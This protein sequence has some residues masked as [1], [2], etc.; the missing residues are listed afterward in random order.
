MLIPERICTLALISTASSLFNT[1]GFLENLRNRANLFIPRPLDQQVENVKQ[2]LYTKSWLSAPDTLEPV[3]QPFPTNGDR[4]AA[5]EVWKRSQP[6]YFPKAGFLL[7]AIAAGWHYKSP[8][9]LQELA[10]NVGKR[11]ILVVHGTND[12]MLKFPL[13]VVLWRGLEKGEGRTGRE[14]IGMERED[15]V[16]VEGEVEKRFIR[17]QG[18]VIPAEMREEF[19]GWLEK[20]FERGIK[21]NEEE[22]I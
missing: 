13:G 5:N 22:G 12:Q 6:G 17:G 21:M 8:Q 1:S 4:F 14:Y 16:W 18:H 19:N 11:R 20:L 3:V 9:Q 2:N 15:D 7:Q 10:N